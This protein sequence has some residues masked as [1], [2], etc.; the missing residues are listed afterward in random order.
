MQALPEK[1][2]QRIDML[3]NDADISRTYILDKLDFV[4]KLYLE[5]TT[6][7][8]VWSTIPRF[9]AYRIHMHNRN[10]IDREILGTARYDAIVDLI[11]EAK[12]S[13]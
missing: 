2:Q 5:C 4:N 6:H 9:Q 11:G 8:E 1:I 13:L 3:V 12:A 10:L 7:R